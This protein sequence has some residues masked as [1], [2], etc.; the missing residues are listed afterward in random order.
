MSRVAKQAAVDPGMM[1][2]SRAV[3]LLG[4]NAWVSTK[5]HGVHYQLDVTKVMFSS[6]NTTERR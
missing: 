2:Q 4:E 3:L 1:R 6:G 5:Q